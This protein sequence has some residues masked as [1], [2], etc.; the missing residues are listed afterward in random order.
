[1]IAKKKPLEANDFAIVPKNR[2]VLQA[3]SAGITDEIN[4]SSNHERVAPPST[5]HPELVKPVIYCSLLMYLATGAISIWIY[6][7][8][9]S[10]SSSYLLGGCLF[11]A[12][13]ILLAFFGR[14]LWLG[15]SSLGSANDTPAKATQIT[16]YLRSK[17]MPS[18]AKKRIVNKKSV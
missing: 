4:Q 10:K 16:Q 7:R 9:G 14:S 13:C 8:T 1:M 6:E 2:V 17:V 3:N 5:M 11:I 18:V 15:K 12:A